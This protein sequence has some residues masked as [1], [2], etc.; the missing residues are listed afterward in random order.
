MTYG[1]DPAPI[2]TSSAE[3]SKPS[4]TPDAID[5]CL[6]DKVAVALNACDNAAKHYDDYYKGFVALDGKAQATATVSGLVLAAVAAFVKDGRVPALVS[7]S[8][9]WILVVLAPPVSALVSVI[10]ALIG[11][12][13]TEVTVPFDSPEQ[14]REAKDLAELD[15]GEFSQVHVLNYYR[16]RLEHWIDAI[17]SIQSVVERKSGWIL[18]GQIALILALFSLLA[19]Y[20]VTLLKA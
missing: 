5:K 11:A 14:I 4:L 7:G 13:V 8:R 10:L 6:R 15:C 2:T 17:E 9:W 1:P 18:R 16:A 12:K 19:L 3:A 20:I